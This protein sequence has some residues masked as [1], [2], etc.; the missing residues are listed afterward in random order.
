MFVP[1]AA[2]SDEISTPADHGERWPFLLVRELLQ[3]RGVAV[4]SVLG[5]DCD[6]GL[7]LVEDLGDATLAQYLQKHPDKY[8][9]LYQTAVR[10]LALAQL[11][12]ENLPADCIVRKRFF[13]H[14]LLRW[15]IDHFEEWALRARDIHLAP[16][17][18]TVFDTAATHIAS[19]IAS[20]PKR[21][22]HRDYQSRNLMV[23]PDSNGT[24]TLVWIDFQDALLGPRVYDL[25]ALLNDSY[26]TFTPE[27]VEQRLREYLETTNLTSSDYEQLRWEFDVVTLQRKL[28][29]AGRFV[30]IDR[31][32]GNPDYL[33]FV[34]PTIAKI[35]LAFANLHADPRVAALEACLAPHLGWS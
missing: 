23:R 12:L 22:V 30:F 31:I 32:K 3:S 34:E 2:K 25:V 28:K 13:D 17:E 35:R 19:T 16:N 21:F 11:R 8:E 6:H 33:M 9:D 18:K 27:F 15:E 24:A 14:T 1:E 4:P 26:Q 5:Q 7:I 10:D 20:W 29:D